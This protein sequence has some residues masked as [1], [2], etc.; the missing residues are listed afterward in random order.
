MYIYTAITLLR[1]EIRCGSCNSLLREQT[2][3]SQCFVKLTD[4][5]ALLQQRN[6][7]HCV[8]MPNARVFEKQIT[9]LFSIRFRIM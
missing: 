8:G 9:L 5:S 6:P 2:A 7:T 1:R 4:V 3:N